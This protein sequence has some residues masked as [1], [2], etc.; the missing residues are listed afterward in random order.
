M[1][2]SIT[3]Q[4]AALSRH[5]LQ[6]EA[7]ADVQGQDPL[8]RLAEAPLQGCT[9]HVVLRSL[10]ICFGFRTKTKRTIPSVP[11]PLI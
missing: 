2:W 9:E 11:A 10:G 5:P 6:L 7:D 3:A 1:L 8:S 4:Q